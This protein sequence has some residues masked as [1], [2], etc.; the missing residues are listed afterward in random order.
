MGKSAQ[1]EEGR[2]EPT[3]WIHLSSA[4]FVSKLK[5]DA[6]GVNIDLSKYGAV[7][8]MSFMRNEPAIVNDPTFI[9]ADRTFMNL[10]EQAP[11]FF[12][13]LFLFCHLVDVRTGGY[14]ALAYAIGRLFYYPL[15]NSPVLLL[16]VVTIPNYLE[17]MAMLGAVVYK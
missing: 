6:G 7:G 2:S 12:V 13:T 11:G 4:R 9:R 16:S 5:N 3:W 1:L 14:I 15:Y 17:C 10:V 8:S